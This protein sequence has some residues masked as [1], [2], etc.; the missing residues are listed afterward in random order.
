[1]RVTHAGERGFEETFG[2]RCASLRVAQR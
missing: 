1:M 2:I